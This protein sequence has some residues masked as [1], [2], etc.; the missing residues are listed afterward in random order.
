MAAP[1][2]ID[3]PDLVH[4]LVDQPRLLRRDDELLEERLHEPTRHAGRVAGAQRV[5][6]DALLD[7]LELL[8]ATTL[9]LGR[10]LRRRQRACGLVPRPEARACPPR[11]HPGP[12]WGP[13]PGERLG[14]PGLLL[15]ALRTIPGRAVLD[16]G[17]DQALLRGRR[18]HGAARG[19]R[20]GRRGASG[21]GGRP[22]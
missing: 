12:V 16:A 14:A 1:I 9:V 18:P 4:H 20:D 6:L 5:V 19:L 8:E 7:A 11:P 21:C 22:C 2:R 10:E 3:A 17:V 13:L 15:Q